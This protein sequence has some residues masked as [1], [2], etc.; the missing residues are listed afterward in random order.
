MPCCRFQ[1]LFRDLRW[2]PLFGPQAS[3]VEFIFLLLVRRSELRWI[4][5]RDL[6]K[7]LCYSFFPSGIMG[8]DIA[9]DS[10]SEKNDDFSAKASRHPK[11]TTRKLSYPVDWIS[12]IT[13]GHVSLFLFYFSS[14]AAFCWWMPLFSVV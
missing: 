4:F 1:L 5:F 14:F 9:I 3:I 8:Y 7:N 6:S 2:E 11:T 10:I 13:F 12:S